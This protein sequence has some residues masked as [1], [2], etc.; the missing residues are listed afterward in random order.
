MKLKNITPYI[1]KKKVYFGITE[2]DIYTNLKKNGTL[3][4]ES[5]KN[6]KTVR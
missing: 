5:L 3:N 1:E 4:I 6:I 2:M